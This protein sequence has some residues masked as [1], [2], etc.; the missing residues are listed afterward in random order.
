M[1]MTTD[2]R[3]LTLRAAAFSPPCWFNSMV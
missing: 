2:S 3:V 1:F